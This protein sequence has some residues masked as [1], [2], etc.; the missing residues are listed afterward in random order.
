MNNLI[1]SESRI[2]IVPPLFIDVMSIARLVGPENKKLKSLQ[3]KNTQKRW[4]NMDDRHYMWVS[5][6]SL[7]WASTHSLHTSGLFKK[8]V[9]GAYIRMWAYRGLVSCQIGV[10]E[11]C[12]ITSY[13]TVNAQAQTAL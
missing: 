13:C 11:K 8:S 9:R 3:E 2:G 7:G 1:A 12:F 4:K 5:Q 6:C 10:P